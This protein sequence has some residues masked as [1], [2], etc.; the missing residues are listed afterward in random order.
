[1]CKRITAKLIKK[2]MLEYE[3]YKNVFGTQLLK[4]NS[5]KKL[6]DSTNCHQ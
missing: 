1:M 6:E 3:I 5:N 4:N 2:L